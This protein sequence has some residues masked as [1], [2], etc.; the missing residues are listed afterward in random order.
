MMVLTYVKVMN[1]LKM[2]S[3]M[4]I[5]YLIKFVYLY[6]FTVSMIDDSDADK[7]YE[8]I[9]KDANQDNTNIWLTEG[10]FNC[11]ILFL[12]TLYA[13]LQ[14]NNYLFICNYNIKLL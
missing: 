4:P 9:N 6:I 13:Y 1:V 14:C 12:N 10:L 7:D 5:L 11:I 8:P 3:Y 2:V